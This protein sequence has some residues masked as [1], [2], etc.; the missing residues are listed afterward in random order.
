MYKWGQMLQ[1]WLVTI[2]SLAECIITMETDLGMA[3]R[4]FNVAVETHLNVGIT[5]PWAG[6]P[7]WRRRRK[8]IAASAFILCFLIATPYDQP[9]HTPTDARPCHDGLYPQTASPNQPFLPY[10]ASCPEFWS[11]HRGKK[12]NRDP[13]VILARNHFILTLQFLLYILRQTMDTAWFIM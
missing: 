4:K 5:I 6:R 9:P 13:E 7:H 10:D 8:L 11:Q 2:A 12:I 1:W 3:R